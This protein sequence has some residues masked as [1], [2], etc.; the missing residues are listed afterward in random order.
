MRRM[1]ALMTIAVLGLALSVAR[2]GDTDAAAGS[3]KLAARA[4][5]RHRGG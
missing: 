3:R 2:K 1:S 5:R 4:A